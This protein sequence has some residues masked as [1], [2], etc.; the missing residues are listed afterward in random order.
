MKLTTPTVIAIRTGRSAHLF[1]DIVRRYRGGER[2][3]RFRLLPSRRGLKA[4]PYQ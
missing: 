2:G 1:K 3:G 4:S